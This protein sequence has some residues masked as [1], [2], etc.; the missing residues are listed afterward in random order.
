MSVK[1]VRGKYVITVVKTLSSWELNGRL[2]DLQ[3]HLRDMSEGLDNVVLVFDSYEAYGNIVLEWELTGQ[4]PATKE[5]IEKYEEQRKKDRARRAE[6]KREE[7]AK[8]KALKIQDDLDALNRAREL[9]EHMSLE[10]AV[11]FIKHNPGI[12]NEKDN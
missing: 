5:E 6:A 4:R 2:E 7:D 10:D 3:K 9:L 1:K 11:A 12:S 8:R